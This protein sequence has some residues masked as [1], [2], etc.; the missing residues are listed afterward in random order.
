MDEITMVKNWLYS[1]TRFD[2]TPLINLAIDTQD[3]DW[4][5][6]LSGRMNYY[7]SCGYCG[8]S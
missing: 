1:N 3:E 2:L 6:T 8:R 7:R 4:F 5:Y